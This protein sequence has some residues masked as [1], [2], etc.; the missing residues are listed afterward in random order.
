MESAARGARAAGGTTIGILPGSDRRQANLFIDYA[1]ATGLGEA[2]NCIVARSSDALISVG[3]GYGTLSEIAFALK[4]GRPVVGL[5]SWHIHLE[6]E[7]RDHL[8]QAGSPSEAVELAL[9]LM[10]L[11][12]VPL[13]G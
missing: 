9:G 13:E 5:K 11:N 10:K 2:R 6:G 4:F 12:R 1:I 3:G 8:P 7:A